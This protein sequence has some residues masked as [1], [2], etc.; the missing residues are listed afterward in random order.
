MLRYAAEH[1]NIKYVH[2]NADLTPGHWSCSS[3]DGSI[4]LPLNTREEYIRVLSSAKVSL[5]GSS[6]MDNTRAGTNGICFATPRFYESAILGCALLGR[7]PDNQEFADLNMHKYCPNITSYEH[8]CEEL[9]HA[10]TQTPE[11]LYAQ[12]RDFILN[13]LTSKRAQQIQNDLEAL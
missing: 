6:G 13:S 11:E 3:T 10:L 1:P 5:V 12:N 7:Y 2:R 8:F 4:S 9:E